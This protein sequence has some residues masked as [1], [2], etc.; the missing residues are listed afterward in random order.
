MFTVACLDRA[1]IEIKNADNQFGYFAQI[2]YQTTDHRNL[3][4]R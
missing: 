1:E 3:A 4:Y 2:D